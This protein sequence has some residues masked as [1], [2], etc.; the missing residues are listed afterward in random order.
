MCSERVSTHFTGRLRRLASTSTSASSAYTC[1]F[2]PKPPPTSG[3]H[4]AQLVLGD[5]EHARQHEPRDVRD[6]GG[7]VQRDAVRPRLARCEPRGSIGAP[8]VRWLTT[9]CSIVTSASASAWS[10]SP[11][12]TAH[13]WV[14]LVPNCSHTSGEPSSSAFSGSTTAGLGSSSAITR[15]AASAACPLV[16]ATTTAIGSPTCLTSP[17]LSGQC[18]GV[19]MSTPGGS[20]TIGI[21]PAKSPASSSPVNT[22]TTPGA[23]LASDVSIEVIVACASGE[24]T[25]AMCSIPG[26]A[27]SS[28]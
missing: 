22:A 6:L 14:L 24:R 19:L 27:M 17:F 8:E 13:S 15:S 5:L 1:S 18:S 3:R 4:H 12:A 9:R 23:A 20:H 16:S 7:R 21:G 26:R 25:T 2:A 11:P 10:K 28:M